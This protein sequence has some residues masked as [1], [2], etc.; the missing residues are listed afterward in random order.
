MPIR[1]YS[2]SDFG[3]IVKSTS[4]EEE[5]CLCP[6]HG[7]S[8]ASASFNTFTG[9]FHCF[10]C[11]ASKNATQL[12]ED[13][14]I[15]ADAFSIAKEIEFDVD[16]YETPGISEDYVFSF[17]PNLEHTNYLYKRGIDYLG[18]IASTSLNREIMFLKKPFYGIGFVGTISDTGHI[19]SVQVR[20]IGDG[21]RYLKLGSIMPWWPIRNIYKEDLLVV[22]GPFAALKLSLATGADN[23]IASLGANVNKALLEAVPLT[24]VFV[25]DNDRAGIE[26]ARRLKDRGFRTATSTD[27]IDEMSVDKL[28]RFYDKTMEFRNRADYF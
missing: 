16:F 13:F 6:Y 8:H 11:G 17:M 4:G 22:E 9:L 25:F 15:D 28:K 18:D 10:A 1:N 2:A 23:I 27:E 19:Q 24:T 20:N 21:S 12:A 5:H 26:A 3:L 7:D 14:G